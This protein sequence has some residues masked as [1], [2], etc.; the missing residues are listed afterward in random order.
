[1]E[2]RMSA[3]ERW[4]SKQS[5]MMA[6]LQRDMSVVK[7][8]FLELKEIVEMLKDVKKSDKRVERGKDFVVN[9]KK[10]CGTV[11]KVARSL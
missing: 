10:C 6:D 3:L 8:G 11:R 9:T 2:G 4:A 1:M 7:E 5:K